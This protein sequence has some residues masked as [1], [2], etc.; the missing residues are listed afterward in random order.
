MGW[1]APLELNQFSSLMKSDEAKIFVSHIR[2]NKGPVNS[3][4][5]K[6]EANYITIVRH[7]VSQ[8]KSAWLYYSISELAHIPENIINTILKSSDALQ[9]IQ[10]RL[11]K[12]KFPVRFF[13]FSNSNLYDMGLEQE[14]IQNM[15]LVES[16]INK[17]ER[18]FDLVMITIT[19]MNHWYYLN[20]CCWELRRL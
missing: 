2:F 18:E 8:F 5:P 3:V 17:M 1:P 11:N 15:K 13:H 20:D 6:P 19:L 16:Y 7:P 9:K 10:K 12:T 14:N 4:F